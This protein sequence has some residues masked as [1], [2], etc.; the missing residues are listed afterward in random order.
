MTKALTAANASTSVSVVAGRD[1]GMQFLEDEFQEVE[2]EMTRL[3]HWLTA[4]TTIR[5]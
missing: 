2:D 4:Q 5:S 1:H 3:R